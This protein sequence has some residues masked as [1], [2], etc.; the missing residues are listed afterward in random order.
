[1][2]SIEGRKLATVFA[3]ALILVPV[4][5]TS[6]PAAE[7]QERVAGPTDVDQATDP[8]H[9]RGEAYY[10][11]ML[12]QRALADRRAVDVRREILRALDLEPESSGLHAEAAS[13]LLQ[14]GHRRDAGRYAERALE[15][16]PDQKTAKR[17]RADIALTQAGGRRSD[18]GMEEAIRLYTELA[19]DPD[20]DD[21][22]LLILAQLELQTGD[23]AAAVGYAERL[24][25]R[26]PGDRSV[27]RLLAD[28]LIFGQR[29][30][31]ALKIVLDYVVGSPEDASFVGFA[32]ELAEQTG[33]WSAV[34]D[35]CVRLRDAGTDRPLTG[36]LCADSF[37]AL[38]RY[39][40]A[41]VELDSALELY[42]DDAGLRRAAARAY[43]AV[44]RFAEGGDLARALVEAEPRDLESQLVIASVL[45]QQGD[46]DGALDAYGDV[47]ASV[48]ANPSVP[49]DRRDWL[50]LRMARLLLGD[51]RATESQAILETLELPESEEALE[52]RA[53]VAVRSGETKRA[54]PLLKRL[55]GEAPGVAA[56]VETEAA[57]VNGDLD[58]AEASLETAVI[59]LGGVARVRGA[60][61]LGEFNHGEQQESQLRQWVRDEPESSA[62]RFALGGF[63]ERSGRFELAENELRRVIESEP[64]HAAA[65]NYLG[66][67][68]AD[69]DTRL[70]EALDLIQRALEVDPWNGAYLDSLGWVYFRMGRFQEAR[71]PLERAAREY[72][73]DPT[74]LEHLGDLYH[75]LGRESE[76]RGVWERA[77]EANPENPEPL[78]LKLQN[79]ARSGD[80][81]PENSAAKLESRDRPASRL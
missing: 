79:G 52:L 3:S 23:A 5:I 26:H 40:D 31:D 70:D 51:D 38:D 16:D 11:L 8:T 18:E 22:V 37:L 10:H 62:A 45:V 4:G 58:G 32:Q 41:V 81:E 1:V 6:I 74:V 27:T 9:L 67:S 28:A 25:I 68:L 61:L 44:G 77:L 36:A 24:A 33:D 12:A 7:M 57:L 20:V 48:A 66:Y 50:R 73:R 72:P 53:R 63:L 42:P 17:V 2:K 65:L 15:L 59:E 56:L 55:R 30:E 78:M 34:A 14:A 80:D 69:R 64:E 46:I 76:A 54:K 43:S 60:Q 19:V 21:E 71:D 75:R 47:L 13:L 35:A 49:P 39:R 29:A